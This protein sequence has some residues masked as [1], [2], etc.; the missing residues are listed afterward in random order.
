MQAI[1][2][3]SLYFLSKESRQCVDRSRIKH[4]FLLQK[5]C[6]KLFLLPDIRVSPFSLLRFYNLLISKQLSDQFGK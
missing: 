4:E 1:V 6:G 5:V 3:Q 2:T